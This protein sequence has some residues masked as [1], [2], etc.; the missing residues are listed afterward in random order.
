MDVFQNTEVYKI[1]NVHKNMD[2][3]ITGQNYAHYKIM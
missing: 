3:Y 2:L 1:I